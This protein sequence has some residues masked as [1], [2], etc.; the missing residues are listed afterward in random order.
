MGPRSASRT[1]CATTR[2][3]P[4]GRVWQETLRAHPT[5]RLWAPDGQ[6]PSLAGSYL[7]ACTFLMQLYGRSPVGNAHWAGLDASDAHQ[8]QSSVARE[9][10][11]PR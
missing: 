10:S 5:L 4:V 3:V 6:H 8:I 11:A 1:A 2:S 7:V 9:M